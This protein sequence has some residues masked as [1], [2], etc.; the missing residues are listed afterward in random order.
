MKETF[1]KYFGSKT[2]DGKRVDVIDSIVEKYIE[3]KT[4]ADVIDSIP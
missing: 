1:R 3:G 2:I 4:I